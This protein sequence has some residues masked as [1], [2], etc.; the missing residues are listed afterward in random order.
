MIE[1][2]YKNLWD[3]KFINYILLEK[4]GFSYR[5]EQDIF[6]FC[7]ASRPTVGPTHSTVQRVTTVFWGECSGMGMKLTYCHCSECMELCLQSSIC[8][9]IM[10]HYQ[11]QG[12]HYL[13]VA[14]VV[15]IVTEF[16]VEYQV[17]SGWS[18]TFTVT[19]MLL[20]H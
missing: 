19:Q 1:I 18:R 11:V 8:L 10:M 17:C 9:Y 7:I 16:N 13:S 20:R 15:T 12:Q 6:Q 2:S 4:F 3:S 5:Q 14:E